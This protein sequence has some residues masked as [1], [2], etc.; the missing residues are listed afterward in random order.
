MSDKLDKFIDSKLPHNEKGQIECLGAMYPTLDFLC[1]W[2]RITKSYF[3]ARIAN[4]DKVEDIL[5]EAIQMGKRR[6]VHDGKVYSSFSD[7]CKQNDAVPAS[8]CDR[9]ASGASLSDALKASNRSLYKVE[10]KGKT[11]N[12]M[13][14]LCAA[15]NASFSTVYARLNKG[16][17]LEQA[18]ETPLHARKVGIIC[19]NKEYESVVSLAREYN[20]SIHALRGRLRAGM[21]PEEAVSKDVRQFRK[22]Y[23]NGV[24]YRSLLELCNKNNIEYES[25][26]HKLKSGCTID[27]AI[28]AIQTPKQK[29]Y[30]M[31]QAYNS[32]V[33]ACKAA[34]VSVYAVGYYIRKYKIQN[35]DIPRIIAMYVQKAKKEQQKK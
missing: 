13:T 18:L 8:V 25:L 10:Y 4:N 19:F 9:I 34:G 20:I 14:Q 21:S 26:L 33:E 3:A 12:S 29:I 1:E 7:M 32:L 35:K 5:K 30:Y 24:E 27:E 17:T 31:G 2:F 16:M 6:I 15:Y 28:E 23:Y 22:M 11:Y